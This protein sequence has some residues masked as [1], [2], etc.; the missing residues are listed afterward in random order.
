MSVTAVAGDMGR[1]I[2]VPRCSLLV[3]SGDQRGTERTVDGDH[4]RI[5]KSTDT[6][7]HCQFC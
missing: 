1:A 5:G 4:F 6:L 3:I 7:A 2:T